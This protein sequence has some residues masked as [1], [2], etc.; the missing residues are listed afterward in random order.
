MQLESSPQ[1][2]VSSRLIEAIRS[3]PVEWE[4]EHCGGRM[5]V[6]PFAFYATC[7][8]CGYRIK[9]RAFTAALEIE[10]VFDA[11]FEWMNQPRAQEQVQQRQQ[12][13]AADAKDD[14]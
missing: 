13:I 12:A 3:L 4:V 8:Q 2:K 10:D 1:V 14:E 11:V 6:S 5:V 9:L 7:P